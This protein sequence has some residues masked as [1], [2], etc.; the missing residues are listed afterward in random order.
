LIRVILEIIAAVFLIIFGILFLLYLPF[1]IS[2][3]A[4]DAIFIG[5][6]ALIMRRAFQD[7]RADRVRTQSSEKGVGKERPGRAQKG[8]NP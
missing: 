8:K 2:E 7:R 1:T 6:G 3:L 4:T 5:A